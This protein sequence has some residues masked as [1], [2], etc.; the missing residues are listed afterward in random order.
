MDGIHLNEQTELN[1]R[2]SSNSEDSL[3]AWTA[4]RTHG[5]ARGS[6]YTKK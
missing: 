3:K 1:F 2:L 4:I 5:T 6:N